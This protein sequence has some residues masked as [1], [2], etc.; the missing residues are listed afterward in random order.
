VEGQC[1]VLPTPRNF[2]RIALTSDVG[3]SRRV[4][5]TLCGPKWRLKRTSAKHAHTDVGDPLPTRGYENCCFAIGL[6]LGFS[7]PRTLSARIR[8]SPRPQCDRTLSKHIGRMV[9][10]NGVKIP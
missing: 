1:D 9:L 7:L 2:H 10:S 4:P 3:T 8:T 5:T 6:N